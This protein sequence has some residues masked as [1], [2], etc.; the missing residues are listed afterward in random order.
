[1]CEQ[2]AA[3]FHS[4]CSSGAFTKRCGDRNL[5]RVSHQHVATFEPAVLDGSPRSSEQK[6]SINWDA[7]QTL[8]ASRLNPPRSCE[9]PV[10]PS[11]EVM[12][13]AHV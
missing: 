2:A 5:L 8:A 6:R 12:R 11:L 9:K 3:V 1:M 10:D 13:W 4:D 7:A